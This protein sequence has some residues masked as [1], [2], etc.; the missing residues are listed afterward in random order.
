MKEKLKMKNV[1]GAGY[2]VWSVSVV[3]LVISCRYEW[4]GDQAFLRGLMVLLGTNLLLYFA[5]DRWMRG[6]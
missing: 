3:C 6:G 2:A 5:V 1:I 4:I